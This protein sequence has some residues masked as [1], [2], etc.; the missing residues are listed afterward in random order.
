MT[1]DEFGGFMAR[2]GELFDPATAAMGEIY[3]E[4]FKG[5]EPALMKR[6]IFIIEKNHPYRRFPLIA[7]IREALHAARFVRTIDDA[8]SRAPSLKG[9]PK[10][11]GGSWI[12]I[13]IVDKETGRER[14]AMTFCDCPLGERRREAFGEERRREGDRKRAGGSTLRYAEK[15]LGDGKSA[16]AGDGPLDEWGDENKS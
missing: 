11:E 15:Y 7:E 2:L 5:I 4:H 1:P 13:K 16:A 6:A 8:E 14:E 9:C 12:M 3:Y 10:C